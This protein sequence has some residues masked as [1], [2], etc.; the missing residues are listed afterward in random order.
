M[1]LTIKLYLVK[2][3]IKGTERVKKIEATSFMDGWSLT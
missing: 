2:I 3:G 1:R